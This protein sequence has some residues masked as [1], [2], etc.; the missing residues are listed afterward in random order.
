MIINGLCCF[1]GCLDIEFFV[2]FSNINLGY[3]F[4]Y[5]VIVKRNTNVEFIKGI[6]VYMVFIRVIEVVI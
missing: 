1:C 2:S 4:I 5:I 6:S 3:L